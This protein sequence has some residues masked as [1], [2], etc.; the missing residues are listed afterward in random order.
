MMTP[1][2]IPLCSMTIIMH[3][4]DTLHPLPEFHFTVL[5]TN[6]LHGKKPGYSQFPRRSGQYG[7]LY[8]A[9]FPPM[10]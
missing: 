10:V 6:N 2:S 1:I 4:T 5:V 8:G 9:I 7:T 3:N